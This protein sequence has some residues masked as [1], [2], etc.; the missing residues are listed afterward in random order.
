[1]MASVD[2]S[3]KPSVSGHFGDQVIAQIGGQLPQNSGP[4]PTPLSHLCLAIFSD[5]Y[6]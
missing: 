2:W 3:T 5:H 1:M 6:P 4:F